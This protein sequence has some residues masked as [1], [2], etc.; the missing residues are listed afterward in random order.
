[1]YGSSIV[2]FGTQKYKY[3]SGREG[4]WLAV[5]FAPRKAAMVVYGVIYYGKGSD[6][7]AKLGPHTEGK[8]CLYIKDLDKID[9]DILKQMIQKA[10]KE[11]K[12]SQAI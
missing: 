9:T 2:A 5:G 7:A 6:M 12:Y 1:M 11:K 3:A 10:L 8:G 4:E